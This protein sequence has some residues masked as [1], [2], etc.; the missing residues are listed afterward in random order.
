MPDS[1]PISAYFDLEFRP[2]RSLPPRQFWW[3]VVGTAAVF[4]LMGLRFLFLGA[5]PIVP[6]MIIDVALMWW[7]MRASYRSGRAVERLRLDGR[8]LEFISISHHGR[9]WAQRLNPARA[10]TELE[11]LVMQQNRL[12]L[13]DDERRLRIA[14]M[15]SPPERVEVARVIED[16]LRRYRRTSQGA[17]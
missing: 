4:L 15:L 2:N 13:R 9:M 3:I 11:E 7:A 17:A 1:K 12:W 5:W 8:G 16:G 6:F 14:A 10:R